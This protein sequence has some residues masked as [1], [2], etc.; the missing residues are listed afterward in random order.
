MSAVEVLEHRFANAV[1][2]AVG[3]A[4][5]AK[6]Y[7][8]QR[9]AP[10]LL[11]KDQAMALRLADEIRLETSCTEEMA[12]LLRALIDAVMERIKAGTDAVP[13]E[14]SRVDPET[15]LSGVVHKLDVAAQELMHYREFLYDFQRSVHTVLDLRA[16][17]RIAR[18]AAS[19]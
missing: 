2:E 4:R 6:W 9:I 13:D 14:A 10:R 12:A 8:G 11:E 3:F 18:D 1:V 5:M 7:I 17:M 19:A 16:A 15:K